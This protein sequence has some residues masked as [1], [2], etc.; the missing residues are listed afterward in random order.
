METHLTIGIPTCARPQAIKGCL[1]SLQKHLTVNHQIIVIDSAINDENLTLY[2]SIPHLK[3]LT[4]DSPIG[5][6]EARKLIIEKTETTV[7]YTVTPEQFQLGSEWK[8]T[9]K[10]V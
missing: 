5:P 2:K 10:N 7:E 3:Y 6:S 1:D 4:F 8:V 9:F